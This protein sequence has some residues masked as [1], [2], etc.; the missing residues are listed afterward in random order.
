MVFKI[1]GSGAAGSYKIIANAQV[2]GQA[3]SGE[4]TPEVPTEV[5]G[6]EITGASQTKGNGSRKGRG[7]SHTI[8]KRN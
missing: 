8:W 2:G 6:N 1:P 7:R 4:K 5:A 3:A